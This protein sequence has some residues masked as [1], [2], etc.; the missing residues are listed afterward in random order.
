MARAVGAP[1][2]PRRSRIEGRGVQFRPSFRS[3]TEAVVF[4]SARRSQ[5]HETEYPLRTSSRS[6]DEAVV[7]VPRAEVGLGRRNFLHVPGTRHSESRRPSAKTR[8]RQHPSPPRSCLR[9]PAQP[10]RP[11]WSGRAPGICRISILW[12]RGPRNAGRAAAK[13]GSVKADLDP[14]KQPRRAGGIFRRIDDSGTGRVGRWSSR[15]ANHAACPASLNGRRRVRASPNSSS[16]CA[17]WLY[18]TPT[19]LRK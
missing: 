8:R 3:D 1:R 11:K 6:D 12:P 14:A 15:R 10:R 9:R 7:S 4:E 2:S 5:N 13:R 19:G 16:L 17:A 18:P